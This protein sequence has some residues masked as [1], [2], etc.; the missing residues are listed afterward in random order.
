MPI[1]EGDVNWPEV[2][3]A[4]AEIGYT[5]WATAEVKGGDADWV[6]EKISLAMDRCVLGK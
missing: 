5:G 3:K 2:R 1:G 4:L 6:K